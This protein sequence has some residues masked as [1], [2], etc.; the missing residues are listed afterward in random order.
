MADKPDYSNWPICSVPHQRSPEMANER[1][2]A[3]IKPDAI[4]KRCIGHILAE[5]EAERFEI[6]AM[7][8]MHMDRSMAE[9]FYE[10]HEGR[11]FF[12]SLVDF[13]VSGPVV[14]LVLRRDEAIATWR[15]MMG[16]TDPVKARHEGPGTLRARCGECGPANAVHGSDSI[17]AA[18]REASI[19][20]VGQ[21]S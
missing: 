10:E 21:R 20:G 11:P 3:L 9:R 8:L 18:D 19:L 12:V 2:V 7:T 1:T 6:E 17:E 14:A 15:R 4:R 5:I 16:P 13:M